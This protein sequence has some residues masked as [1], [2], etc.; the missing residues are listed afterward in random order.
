MRLMTYLRE[1][2]SRVGAKLDDRVI[3][4]NRAYRLWWLD[5]RNPAEL[6]AADARVPV[7]MLALLAGGKASLDAAQKAVAFVREHL[8]PGDKTLKWQGVAYSLDEITLRPPV[9]RPGKII[10]VGLNYLPP[11]QEGQALAP[12]YPVL[13]HKVATT[14]TAHG[15]PIVIPR[16]SQQVLCEGEL[17]VVIGKRGKHIEPRDALSHVA[18]YTIANDVGAADL[19]RRSSQWATGKLPD[20]FCPLGPVLVTRDE[21]PDPNTLSIKTILSGQL[22]QSGNTQEMIFDVPYL[23]SYIS[24]LTTLEPGDVILT[25]SPKRVDDAPAPRIFL[26]PGDTICIKIE[27]L[28]ELSNPIV[29]EE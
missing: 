18:G 22:V 12:P 24:A 11:G 28:G 20:T 7:D 5:N 26:K 1:G 14:L 27:K 8:T 19:E 10:C 17:A 9:L 2:Q 25:G 29:A 13:F 4:L 3:D 21:A 15:Q 23:V 6:A 16:I